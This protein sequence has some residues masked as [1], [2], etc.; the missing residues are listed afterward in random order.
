[1]ILYF[2][3]FLI[4][5]VMILL[6]GSRLSKYGDIIAEKTGLGGSWIGIVFLATI[7]SLPELINCLSAVIWI[8]APVLA[9]GD[10]FGSCVFNIVILALLDILQ[11]DVPLSTRAYYGNTPSASLG[12]LF[13]SLILW[14]F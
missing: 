6:A 14:A 11:K 10:I 4:L 2:V 3:E 7:T 5:A 12:I 9:L 1:M 8:D 13:L